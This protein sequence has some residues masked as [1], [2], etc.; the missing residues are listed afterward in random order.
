MRLSPALLFHPK[1]LLLLAT[2]FIFSAIFSTAAV[3][4]SGI[5]PVIYSQQQQQHQQHQP[6]SQPA[7][8]R[9]IQDSQKEHPSQP[10]PRPNSNTNADGGAGEGVE[11]TVLPTIS[12][13]S[14]PPPPA[15]AAASPPSQSSQSPH[16]PPPS[17]P[18]TNPS[19]SSPLS[20]S[21]SGE[22]DGPLPNGAE[23]KGPEFKYFQEAG[24][25]Y[26]LTHYDARFFR[27]LVPYDEHA[28][29]LRHLIRSY[30]TTF[31]A[32]GLE[33]WLAHGTL[34]GWWWNGR[35]MP[36]DW[37]LDAQVSGAT[38]AALA[39]RFNGSVHEYEVA[40]EEEDLPAAAAGGKKKSAAGGGGGKRRYLLDVNPFSVRVSRGT[41]LN[42]IDA[43]WIDT[44]TGLFV[45]ITGLVERDPRARPGV[46]S[47][48]NHHYY[49]QE[50]LYPLRETEFEGVA[51]LVPWE[52]ENI[53]VTEYGAKSLVLT[54]WEG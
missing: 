36:W 2:L 29:V 8:Q 45:D 5:Q 30:L 54:E 7:Q 17:R 19:S 26:T 14:A 42:M 16:S 9:P 15:E 40:E 49:T 21:S 27:G 48:K 52:F 1:S 43:R 35:I 47:C 31:A 50:E 11:P 22:G 23:Y 44:Q 51:A 12:H 25:T 39:A 37:D 34:L 4:R 3:A 6:Q 33:T 41:G 18:H 24:G 38:M 10:E 20:S 53:L 13:P 28:G 32:L 46:V